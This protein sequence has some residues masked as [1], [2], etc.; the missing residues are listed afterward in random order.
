MGG[1][2]PTCA[3]LPLGGKQEGAGKLR[4]RLPPR[5]GAKHFEIAL[6]CEVLATQHEPRP[7]L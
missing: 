6:L 1:A 2:I 3:C 7:A 5:R 4:L